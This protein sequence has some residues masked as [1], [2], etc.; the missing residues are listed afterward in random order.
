MPSS[1]QTVIISLF[2]L[3]MLPGGAAAQ[4]TPPVA[5]V[6]TRLGPV[7]EELPLTGTITSPRIAQLSPAVGGLVE[8]VLV[9]IGERVEAG[10]SLHQPQ[11]YRGR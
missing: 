7:I 9:E 3:L 2:L 6:E 5:V 4:D 11:A 10:A 1:N 8:Q